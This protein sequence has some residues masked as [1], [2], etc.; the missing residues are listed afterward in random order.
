MERR[1]HKP[2]H[3]RDACNRRYVC[4]LITPSPA[5]INIVLRKR[6]RRISNPRA[7]PT[8]VA[9]IVTALLLA[10]SERLRES[11]LIL[12]KIAVGITRH[13]LLGPITW[14][15]SKESPADRDNPNVPRPKGRFKYFGGYGQSNRSQEEDVWRRHGDGVIPPLPSATESDIESLKRDF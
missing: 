8:S 11:L 7:G 4:L 2:Q 15:R 6:K 9:I 3:E 5:S 12:Q 10:F 1:S 13:L 14:R